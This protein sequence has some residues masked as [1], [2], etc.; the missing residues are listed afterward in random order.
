MLGVKSH[1]IEMKSKLLFSLLAWGLTL[2]AVL[3][4]CST[5]APPTPPPGRSG[6]PYVDAVIEAGLSG[7]ARVLRELI[8]LNPVPCTTRQGLGGPPK[9][10]PGESD[11]AMV[12]AFPILGSEGWYLREADVDT[13]PGIGPVDV[14][15]VYRTGSDT[16]SDEFYPAGEYAVVFAQPGSAE[17]VT[18]QVTRDGIVRLDYGF[19]PTIQELY[20]Q[21]EAD[22]ILGPFA[23]P[24]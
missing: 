6:I 20:Q 21:H 4:S 11:G 9:C 1:K 10:M 15:A 14:Y 22:F 5:A 13:W 17:T 24:D 2:A 12:E 8:R 3:A 7:D 19:R 16:Y 23:L 18:L